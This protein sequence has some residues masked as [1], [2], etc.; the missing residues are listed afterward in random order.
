MNNGKLGKQL[1]TATVLLPIFPDDILCLVAGAVQIDFK[2]FVVVN[3]IGRII[4][5]VT[6]LVFMR[7]PYLS[8]FFSS[9]TNGGIPWALFVYALLLILCFIVIIFWYDL[10]KKIKTKNSV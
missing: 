10:K 8:Q 4:G 5:T 2:F 7:L 1:Y 9:A 3:V 6:L